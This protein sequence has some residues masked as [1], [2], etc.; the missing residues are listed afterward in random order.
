MFIRNISQSEENSARYYHNINK[1]SQKVPVIL[2]RFQRNV[3]FLN[4]FPKNT[5]ISNF[6]KICPVGAELFHEDRWTE[7]MDGRT[8]K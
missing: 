3:N 2:V 4:R 8:N 6:K 5:Q 7:W 1:F